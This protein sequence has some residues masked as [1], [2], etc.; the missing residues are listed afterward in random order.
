M[1]VGSD[2]EGCPV[3]QIMSDPYQSPAPQ[4]H[5][6]RGGSLYSVQGVVIASVLGSLAAG[7][8]MLYLNYRTLGKVVL[9]QR[10]A[11]WGAAIYIVLI[12]IATLLPNTTVLALAYNVFQA[13]IAYFLATQLQGAAIAYHTSQGGSLHSNLRAAGVGFLTGLFLLFMLVFT[14]SLWAVYSGS[15]A[16]A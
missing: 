12:G 11:L 3:T 2:Q 4:H 7:V 1:I 14:A 5:Q 15:A 6:V 16:T 10:W 13:I 9:A 8:V